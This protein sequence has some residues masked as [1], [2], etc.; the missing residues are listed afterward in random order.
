MKCICWIA[1]KKFEIVERPIPK[2]A[3]GEALI[4]VESVGVC[5][6]DIHY[7]LEGRIGDQ[8]IS[9]PLVLGHEFAGI[10]EEVG[11]KDDEHLLGKR[12]AVEPGFPCGECEFC[13]TG[14]YNVCPALRFLG[15]PGCDGALAEYIAVPANFCFPVPEN[16]SAPIASMVE[17]TAVAV[18]T[19]ELAGVL[20]GDTVL[21][22]GLGSIGLIVL[23]LLL[24]S[25]P[26]TFVAGVDL[27][28]YRVDVAKKLGATEV[29]IPPEGSRT[30]QTEHTIRW[31]K[32]ITQGRGFD[33][34]IDCTNQS[35]GLIIACSSAKPA[36]RVVLVGISGKDYDLIPV[37]IARRRELTL[38]WCRRFLF[39]FPTA[40]ELIAKGKIN[41]DFIL[42]HHFRPDEVSKAF[43]MVANNSDNIIKASI[44]WV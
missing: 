11:T 38:K 35:E 22:V 17:P 8:I 25:S 13:K 5:G 3:K 4:K 6:S 42:T 19:M 32:E 41:F 18:H 9:P 31:A 7:Y 44:D 24:N 37:S 14:H 40:I 10:V 39:N 26:T 43:E 15:G 36:G 27:L 2:P 1:P 23:Q 12:V 30:E 33:I 29:F 20:P 16:I 21:V 28:D 34:T